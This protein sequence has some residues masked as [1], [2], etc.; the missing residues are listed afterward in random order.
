MSHSNPTR[1]E[2]LSNPDK[3]KFLFITDADK[4]ALDCCCGCSLRTG[5]Q[6]IS[7][8]F[9]TG[10]M[11]N[12]FTAIR[13]HSAIGLF[14]SGFLFITYFFA[15]VCTLYST[16]IHDYS[17][18]YKGYFVYS[19]IFLYNVLEA[20]VVSLLILTANYKALEGL[21]R[22]MATLIYLIAAGIVLSIHLY[23]LWIIFSYS[24]HLKHKRHGLISGNIVVKYESERTSY[25]TA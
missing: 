16:M 4:L 11:S 22:T 6:I 10:S 14:T 24:I 12:F 2:E 3:D 5:V 1:Q 21:D 23:M 8:L 7:L 25:P 15:G 17:Y 9:I 19:V 20:L 13:M 18:A